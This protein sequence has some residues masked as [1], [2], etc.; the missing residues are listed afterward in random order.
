MVSE[1]WFVEKVALLAPPPADIAPRTHTGT[2]LP[3][4]EKLMLALGV[5][6][7]DGSIA[8]CAARAAKASVITFD[9]VRGCIFAPFL[10]L[11]FEGYDDVVGVS[12]GE[13]R[14]PV[15]AVGC[16]REL[17]LQCSGERPWH[18]GHR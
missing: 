6:A 9:F 10:Y 7:R 1:I 8:A 14:K 3:V 16:N 12:A 15:R 13:E 2:A 18:D 5:S 11:R 4:T 17:Q